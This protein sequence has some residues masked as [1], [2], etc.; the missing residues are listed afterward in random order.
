MRLGQGY[1]IGVQDE[2]L[3]QPHDVVQLQDAGLEAGR[4][5]L[6]YQCAVLVHYLYRHDVRAR[7]GRVA[8]HGGDEVLAD[9]FPEAYALE[10]HGTREYADRVLLVHHPRNGLRIQYLH[11]DDPGLRKQLGDQLV[12]T[13]MDVYSKHNKKPLLYDIEDSIKQQGR[14]TAHR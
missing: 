4:D 13:H 14:L 1:Q 5:V 11:A 12:A 3:R 6:G 8:E 2:R 9:A 10:L 7:E